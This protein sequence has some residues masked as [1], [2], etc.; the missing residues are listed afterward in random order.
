MCKGNCKE[1]K[2]LQIPCRTINERLTVYC[3]ERGR[4]GI[5][6]DSIREI[7]PAVLE[8]IADAR[9][10]LEKRGKEWALYLHGKAIAKEAARV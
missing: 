5:Q 2:R 1:C 6:G 3:F 9:E 8:E 4:F 10:T 7:Y